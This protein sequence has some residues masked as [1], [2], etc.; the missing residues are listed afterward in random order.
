[1]RL[2][3]LD[4]LLAMALVMPYLMVLLPARFQERNQP[5]LLG[6]SM[7]AYAVGMMVASI[8]ATKIARHERF[9]WTL[10]MVL[11]IIGFACMGFLDSAWLVIA[12]MAIS[13]L[14]GGVMRCCD[15]AAAMSGCVEVHA[16]LISPHLCQCKTARPG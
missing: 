13:G 15:D 4:S 6:L 5:E 1:M 8:V 3:A 10:G 16:G 2:L 9:A 14:G 11:Y 7:S 12:G